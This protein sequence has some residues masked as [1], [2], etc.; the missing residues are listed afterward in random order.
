MFGGHVLVDEVWT[1]EINAL[2]C[3]LQTIIRKPQE[4]LNISMQNFG[5]T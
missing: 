4:I 3:D 2:K 1:L 5:K